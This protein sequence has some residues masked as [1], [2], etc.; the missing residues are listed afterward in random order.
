M[1]LTEIMDS[2]NKKKY[3]F[4]FYE[5]IEGKNK[6]KMAVRIKK[7]ETLKDCI[8]ILEGKGPIKDMDIK[9]IWV[10]E[11]KKKNKKEFELIFE[12]EVNNLEDLIK[13]M[14]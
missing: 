6:G 1:Y 2:F 11:H 9:E 7:K 13:E 3:S 12:K 4:H 5:V 10:A 8:F 14:E